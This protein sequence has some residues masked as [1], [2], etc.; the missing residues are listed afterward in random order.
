ML[1]GLNK[2]RIGRMPSSGM[3]C[4][5]TLLRTNVLEEH[6]ISIIRVTQISQLGKT[7]AITATCH[8]DDGGDTFLRNV[9]SYES[10]TV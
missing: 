8:P 5:M 6:I 4:Y 1:V 10:H 3:L 2:L 9:S 7:L